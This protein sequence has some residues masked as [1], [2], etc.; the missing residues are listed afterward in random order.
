[1]TSAPPFIAFARPSI[2]EAEIA[3]VVEK[4]KGITWLT[5][6]PRPSRPSSSASA[7]V[8]TN[9]TLKKVPP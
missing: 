2:G 8:P 1:M 5:M 3:E 9:D 4:G 6:M 7:C